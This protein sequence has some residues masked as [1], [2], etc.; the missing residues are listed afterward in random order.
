MPLVTRGGI[1]QK[2]VAKREKR[3]AILDFCQ[4]V[5]RTRT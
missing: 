5:G 2:T 3:A 1:N 4:P